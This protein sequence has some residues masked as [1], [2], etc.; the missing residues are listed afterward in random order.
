MAEVRSHFDIIAY[1]QSCG[2]NSKNASLCFI[3]STMARFWF[4]EQSQYEL[5]K[6]ALK[7][8]PMG[9][10]LTQ[11]DMDR[12][13]LNYKHNRFSDLI[14]LANPRVLFLP[15]YFQGSVKVKGM[16]GY[17]PEC[18]EQQSAFIIH[19]PIVGV[20]VSYDVPVDM[21]R[22]FPTVLKLLN[23]EIPV[24]CKVDSII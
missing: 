8:L 16:H 9:R 15:N 21:R 2:I 19:S 4:S 18:P 22:V 23:I 24:D 11:E 5:V 1:L 17:A 20:P 12:Y 6:N 13:H 3:D 7:D 10:I 14:F